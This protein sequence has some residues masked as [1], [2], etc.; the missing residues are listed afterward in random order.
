MNIFFNPWKPQS[1]TI[2]TTL[3]QLFR[4]CLTSGNKIIIYRMQNVI[5]FVTFSVW[6]IYLHNSYFQMYLW[7]NYS[8]YVT[9]FIWRNSSWV[10]ILYVPVLWFC[11][12]EITTVCTISCDHQ[13]HSSSL[14]EVKSC[15]FHGVGW[16]NGKSLRCISL[17]WSISRRSQV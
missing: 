6:I 16:K 14:K 8:T 2:S 9:I 7:S 12:Q 17:L 1:R 13:I 3:S 10:F 11:N 4:Y 15:S 5:Q